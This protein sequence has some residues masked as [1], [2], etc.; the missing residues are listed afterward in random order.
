MCLGINKHQ[1]MSP[2]LMNVFVTSTN[3]TIVHQSSQSIACTNIFS[4]YYLSLHV[5]CKKF[6][7]DN[8][9]QCTYIIHKY[10]S[11]I[12]F[13]IVHIW[14]LVFGMCNPFFI[15]YYL[16]LVLI[17]F[18]LYCKFKKNSKQFHKLF[19]FSYIFKTFHFKIISHNF[20]YSIKYMKI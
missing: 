13:T 3:V 11:V 12:I 18:Q 14:F 6:I 4:I 10:K 2:R 19:R 20:T 5:N 9:R 1:T 16:I 7:L 8:F 17:I 15:L